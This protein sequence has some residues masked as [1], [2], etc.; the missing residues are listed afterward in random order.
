MANLL[1]KNII[2]WST[3]I[4]IILLLLMVPNPIFAWHE[5]LAPGD[6]IIFI[7]DF[8]LAPGRTIN[9]FK[10]SEKNKTFRC[11]LHASNDNSNTIIIKSGKQYEITSVTENF[12]YVQVEVK[13]YVG[14]YVYG[15]ALTYDCKRCAIDL[16]SKDCGDLVTIIHQKAVEF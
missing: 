4:S 1:F 2:K 6:K 15:I 11:D 14:P 10:K 8:R 16:F 12:H 3:A 9:L 5:V 13:K 7:K